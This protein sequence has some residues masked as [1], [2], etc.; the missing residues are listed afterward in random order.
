MKHQ[1]TRG[2][3][4]M[5][6]LVMIV[7]LLSGLTV[8]AQ[9]SGYTSN[10]G[11]RGNTATSLS[12]A[13]NAF[14]ANNGTS[15]EALSALSGASD[16][17]AVPSSALYGQLK[18][19]MTANHTY[20]TSYDETKDL[21]RYTDCQGATGP[22]SSFYSGNAIGPDWDGTWNREHTWPNSKGLEGD[23]E[24]DIMMLRPTSSTENSGR[25]NKAYGVSS[26]FYNPNSESGGKYNLHGDVARIALY[27][28]VR[29]GNTGNMWGSSGVI[30]SKEVLL[31]WMQEDPVDTWEL[32][33]NDAVQSITGTR[34]VFVDY[35]E[36]A[37]LL[38]GE[39][40]PADMVTPSGKA[41]QT[42]TITATV[43]D[44][45]MGSVTVSGKNIN[46]VPAEGCMVAGFEVV[47]GTATVTQE[48]NA[49]TVS[50]FSD[51]TVQINFAPK[52]EVT[53]SYL[54]DG[55]VLDTITAYSGDA[56][57]LPAYT[58]TAPEG[59]TFLG[60]TDENVAHSDTLPEFYRPEEEYLLTGDTEIYALFSYVAAG[61]DSGIWTLVTDV[62]QLAAGQQVVL[63]SNEKGVVS[64][65]IP[66]GRAYLFKENAVFSPDFSTITT[67][68]EN[69]QIF[70]LGGSTGAWTFSTDGKLL[71]ATK[72]KNLAYDKGTATWSITIENGDATIQ[73]TT[74]SYGRFLYNAGNPRFTTYTSGV[75]STML[76]PQLYVLDT[77]AG[78]TFYTTASCVHANMEEVP[79]QSASCTVDG[80][81][82]GVYC[83]DC[84]S[85][86]SGH[87]RIA[88]PGHSYAS[89][90]TPP[91][92]TEDGFTTYT[93]SACG[94][95]YV[96]DAVPALG[97]TYTVSFSVPL[98][99]A[100][101]ESMDCNNHGITLPEA[102]VP[103]EAAEAYTF[104][105]WTTAALESA[106]TAPVFY[107]AG[108]TYVAPSDI[109]LYALYSCTQGGTGET[110]YVLVES[111]EQLTAG[112]QIV[113]A[114]ATADVALSTTQNGN[115]R[116]QAE[117]TK[118]EDKT[119]TLSDGVAQL[120]LGEGTVDGTWSFS[121]D[122]N[123]YLYA[124]SSSSNYL[125]TTDTL[126]ANG[127]FAITVDA[128][129]VATIKA[130]GDKTRNWLRYNSGN[131]IFSCYG[132]GQQDVCL[133][134]ETVDGSVTYTTHIAHV[135]KGVYQAG[136]D[137]TCLAPGAYAHYLCACGMKFADEAC[138]QVL[139]DV[140]IAQKAHSFTAEKAEEA[141][142]KSAAS[143][144]APAT[145]YVSCTACGTSSK[146]AGEEATFTVGQKAPDKHTGGT[147]VSGKL[148]AT[149]TVDGHTGDTCCSGCDKVLVSGQVIPATHS[150]TAVD[151]VE[152]TH[153][154][155]GL[156]AHYKCSACQKCFA[157]EL[158]AEEVTEESVILAAL[159]HSYGSFAHDSEKHWK[160]CSCGSKTEEGKHSLSGWKTV[161]DA[162]ETK[163]GQKK[164]SC[165]VC[166]YT[167]TKT[168]PAGSS[169][170]T[171][172]SMPV[173]LLLVL[174]AVSAAGVYG[175]TAMR[176]CKGKYLR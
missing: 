157:D 140:T 82:A 119:I 97:E 158:A 71:G 168:I 152:P 121:P 116:D 36:L 84:S 56:L 32:G 12:N 139:S 49:F 10:W 95:S 123:K 118:N 35:P 77:G 99:A 134:V 7:G 154:E 142:L 107:E 63:A 176:P 5:L 173:I 66:E 90:V 94:N 14:Y 131:K 117:I 2:M 6:A 17:A 174:M 65:A 50:A 166:G 1:F 44:P 76:M 161:T 113:I 18:S 39:E 144:A 45:A 145:Y 51:C 74:Q 104:L 153:T 20:I 137:A 122:E 105:G 106:S 91:T 53:V 101:V 34:N 21:Y 165:S 111:D 109:T 42:Y 61:G 22:I 46:A 132:S 4:L 83:N 8:P 85:Y 89:V 52:T 43:N 175:I 30:E 24:N 108:S 73:N 160:A 110:S 78:V 125:R 124:A 62:S 31:T 3:S 54:S 128:A 115:N 79:A 146:D 33:R 70:T 133:Y 127:S 40:V 120:T 23:D 87:Q 150:L 41:G 75:T 100:K 11:Y 129:G 135:H 155:P 136:A 67:M 88:A 141:Y 37:F 163:D 102:Q 69:A 58:G 149:C 114:A 72:V 172:D 147:Y 29:W 148:D 48:G 171:G 9:A 159:G 57:I 164:R 126:D 169:P 81:T 59:Y 27:V 13:A 86:I 130:Q 16:V 156:A 64:A 167:E 170:S 47:S 80:Y 93:C 151:K 25:G 68:P 143:C 92:A 19:L 112:S 15:Y 162:T 103:A 38:F 96:G 60:W 138:T 55:D 26:G 28:Y 98:D